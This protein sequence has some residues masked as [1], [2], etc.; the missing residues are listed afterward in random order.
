MLNMQEVQ[1]IAPLAMSPNVT[2]NPP[3]SIYRMC[4]N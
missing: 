1:A 3:T 2:P 4:T